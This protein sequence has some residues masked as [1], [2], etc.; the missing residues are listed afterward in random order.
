MIAMKRSENILYLS[1]NEWLSITS[2]QGSINPCATIILCHGLTGDKIGPQK[3]LSDLSLH[4][5]TN[6][7]V[8]VIRFDFQGSELSSGVFIHTTLASMQTNALQIAQN[9]NTPVIWMG[10]STG[11]TVALMAA[12]KREK[13]EKV[14]AI[15]NGFSES[16]NFTHLENDLVPL[17]EG[18]LWLSK[19]YFLQRTLLYPRR[20]YFSKVGSI[21]VILGSED[22]KHFCEYPSLQKLLEVEVTVIEGGDHLFT[23]VEKRKEVFLYL[24]EKV[25]EFI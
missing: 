7:K 6:C 4:L 5:A 19:E 16:I 10:I 2:D 12:A 23:Q 11:A 9:L 3:L 20:N 15:S 22:S 21:S 17:R 14:I 13:K 18:Q 25:S 8:E 1:E 24:E